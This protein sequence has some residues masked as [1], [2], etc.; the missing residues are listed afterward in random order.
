MDKEIKGSKTS[1]SMALSE[2]E[3]PQNLRLLRL[4][5][6]LGLDPATLSQIKAQLEPKPEMP[7]GSSDSGFSSRRGAQAGPQSFP[8]FEKET[9][10]EIPV[11]SLAES[12]SENAD[13]AIDPSRERTMSPSYAPEASFP[14]L[15]T[16]P[17]TRPKVRIQQPRLDLAMEAELKLRKKIEAQQDWSSFRT[18]AWQLYEGFP[19]PDMAARLV[20]LAFLYGSAGELDEVLASL[21]KDSID[22]YT[23]IDG[24]I[25][26]HLVVKLWQAQRWAVLDGLLFRKDL[27]LRLLPLERLYCCWSYLQAG[28]GVQAYKFFRRHDQEIWNAQRLYGP[29]IKHSETQLALLLG[30]LALKEGDE[31]LAMQ[32]LESIPRHAPEFQKALDILLDIRIERD[33]Q[34]L[35]AYG[36]KLQRELDWRGRLGLIDSFLLRVQRFESSAPK[37]RAALNELLKDPLKWF[38]ETPEAWQA[39]AELLLHYQQLEYLLP[40]VLQLFHQRATQYQRPAYDHAIWA[41]VRAFDF[42]HPVRNWFWQ[43]ISLLHEFTWN[44]GQQESLLWEARRHY[45]EA[46]EHHGRPLSISWQNLHRSLLQWIGKTERLEES[47]RQLLM[48]VARLVGESRDISEADVCQY[49]AQVSQPSRQVMGALEKLTQERDQWGLE[50][51]ILDKKALNLHYTNVDLGRV[52]LLGA[53]LKRYDQCWRVASVLRQRQVMNG[54]LERHWSICGEKK[55]EF[56]VLELQESHVKRILSSFDGYDRRLA[57]ALTTVGPLIPELLAGLN[58][59]LVPIKKSKGY[60]EAEQE[61]HNVL[62]RMQALPQPRRLFTTNPSGMWHAKPPFFANL[63]DTKWSLLFMALAQR[64]GLPAWD[65]Q[66]SLLHHQ[67]ETLVPRMAR[68]AESSAT[69]RVGRWLRLLSPQQRKAWYDLAQLSK[70]YNDEEAQILFA[71]FLAKLT[72]T[73][74]EDHTLALQSLEKMRAPLRLRW[75]LEHWIVSDLYGEVRR[76]LGS[77]IIGH[78][79]ED[80]Y[81]SN[82]LAEPEGG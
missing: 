67:I 57:E 37:D 72:T 8:F 13:Q 50:A 9:G 27:L 20:E 12:L 65:W 32:L 71:R 48:V 30:T 31:A 42:G 11:A 3:L 41:P 51:F 46:E 52:W 1:A 76:S 80:V 29:Q 17:E 59:H 43:S 4:A 62:E 68:G 58:Q 26:L 44:N 56:P 28:E 49:L 6:R 15:E 24:E 34:G 22:F 66:L 47:Q 55:R 40:N 18:E 35:C 75:D 74:L 79:P 78:Y 36:Q 54:Q 5:E 23:L 38:P 45:R 82:A 19:R 61:I 64:L 21:I 53:R 39:L 33:D 25:R 14:D 63:L 10:R 2:S 81:A 69:G 73:M 7:D 77:A 16:I 60:T 70:R